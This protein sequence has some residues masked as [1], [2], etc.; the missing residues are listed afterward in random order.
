[1]EKVFAFQSKGLS[2]L[3]VLLKNFSRIAVV[4]ESVSDA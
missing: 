3:A 4:Y 2:V 1:M